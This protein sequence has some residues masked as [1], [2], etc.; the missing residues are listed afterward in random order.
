PQASRGRVT[1]VANFDYESW[2]GSRACLD[3]IHDL[4][5]SER[6]WLAQE[7]RDLPGAERM[8]FAQLPENEKHAWRL[9]IPDN[10]EPHESASATQAQTRSIESAFARWPSGEWLVSARYH[11]ALS[12]AWAGSKI[13][14]IA[15]NE[16]LRGVADEL[17]VPSILPHATASEVSSALRLA[18]P[19]VKP[20]KQA[21]QALNA[22]AEFFAAIRRS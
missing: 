19:S 22:C 17:Q 5:P 1:L 3:A 9:V 21:E 10:A 14:V 11:A 12:G 20:T 18:R 6:V 16:K 15:T 8:L 7:T 4:A 13:V 2:T